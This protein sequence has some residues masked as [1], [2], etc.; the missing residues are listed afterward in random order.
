VKE[1]DDFMNC[2]SHSAISSGEDIWERS[3]G[4]MRQL[5]QPYFNSLRI[6]EN[7][8]IRCGKTCT[9]TSQERTRKNIELM[10]GID[11]RKRTQCM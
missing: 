1:P 6:D 2:F 3:A 8:N 4:D 7:E 9:G 5:W 10:G 11:T